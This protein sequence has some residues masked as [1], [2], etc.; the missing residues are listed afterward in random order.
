MNPTPLT[1]LERFTAKDMV[2]FHPVE[3]IRTEKGTLYYVEDV[4]LAV[5][6]LKE[7]MKKELGVVKSYKNAKSIEEEFRWLFRVIDEAFGG[8]AE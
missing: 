3:L 7:E 8:V 5:A 4:A 2:G 1:K 6:W